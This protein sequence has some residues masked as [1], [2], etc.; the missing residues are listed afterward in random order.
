MFLADG[1]SVDENRMGGAVTNGGDFARGGYALRGSVEEDPLAVQESMYKDIERPTDVSMPTG[2]IQAA[3]GLK[4]AE[5]APQQKQ[6]SALDKASKIA[7]L[8]KEG[9]SGLGTLG[10]MTGLSGAASDLAKGANLAPKLGMNLFPA[11][12]SGTGAADYIAPA[13]ADAA[14][15]SGFLGG[16]GSAL[17]GAGSAIMGGLESLGPLLAFAK[18]GGRIGYAD[19]GAVEGGDDMDA[20]LRPLARIE[21]GGQKDPYSAIGPKTKYGRAL[22]KYQIMEGNVPEWTQA[23]LGRAMTPED[24]I[25]NKEA[26]EATA[27]HRFGQYLDKAG[28]PEGAA[29]MWFGG[30]DYEKHMSARDVLGTSIPQYM[31]KYKAGLGGVDLSSL[32]PRERSMMALDPAERKGLGA[33]APDAKEPEGFL[34]KATQPD[35]LLPALGGLGAALEGM[36]TSPTVG[37]GGALLRGAGAGLGTGAK[38]ALEAP[39]TLAEAEKFR[40]EATKIGGADTAKTLAEAGE[41]KARGLSLIHI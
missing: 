26:Q 13:A 36:V 1:G 10:Q 29:G 9:L 31:A 25:G 6:E 37:I 20:Y 30:P 8:A 33:A 28:T 32:G 21:S 24:F 41:A 34:E 39:K 19:R 7:G 12:W 16:L 23:A 38:L 35:V 27:R 5:F 17:S 40:Q 22:G 15:G 18:D 2:Q 4:P 14:T 11:S 3:Q